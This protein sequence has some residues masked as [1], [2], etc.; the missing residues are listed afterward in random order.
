MVREELVGRRGKQ[1]DGSARTREAKLGCVF[2]QTLRD[3][4]GRAVRDP[5]ST[6]FI[7]AIETAEEFGR[8]LYA[9]AVRRGL[10]QAKQVVL[11]GDAAEWVKQL[12]VMHFPQATYITDLYHAREHVAELCH[13]L[14]CGRD[15]LIVHHR[16]RWWADLDAGR[17][18]KIVK[19]AERQ[20]P[21]CGPT[22]T[23]P[24]WKSPT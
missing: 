24:A 22:G 11:L 23:R 17:V 9:E 15:N 13:T 2:T 7:G 4:D 18:E 19:E 12:Q 8:R 10:Y 16:L 5:D 3:R 1:P 6:S 21:P 14:F 20:L